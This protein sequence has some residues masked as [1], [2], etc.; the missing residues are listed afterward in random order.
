MNNNII[1]IWQIN[2]N[3]SPHAL[4]NALQH[5]SEING[6]FMC[7][8]EIPT[9]NGQIISWPRLNN[10]NWYH[11]APII[12]IP[13]TAVLI[14]SSHKASLLT[15]FSTNNMT[16]VLYGSII[17]VSG[18]FHA[19][20]DIRNDLQILESLQ[21]EFSSSPIIYCVDCNSHSPLWF[22]NHLDTRGKILENFFNYHNLYLLN[23]NT[24]PTWEIGQKCST[25]DL[26]IVNSLSLRHTN[27]W[28]ILD[29]QSYSDHK[30][31]SFEF[32]SN[33][34]FVKCPMDSRIVFKNTEWI[35]FDHFILSRNRQLTSLSTKITSKNCVDNFI[36]VFEKTILDAIEASSQRVVVSR[37]YHKYGSFSWWSPELTGLKKAVNRLRKNISKS[38]PDQV[39]TLKYNYNKLVKLYKDKIS[40]AKI[41]SWQTF[42]ESGN[43]DKWGKL[44][45]FI[46]K[47]KKS[48]SS[49]STIMKE[50][51][52][53]TLNDLETAEYLI[54]K[55]C[56]RN[57]P[58]NFMHAIIET[59]MIEWSPPNDPSFTLLEFRQALNNINF[60]S[61]PGPDSLKGIYL[62]KAFGLLE[63]PLLTVFNRCLRLGY[64]PNAWKKGKIII[65]PKNFNTRS[66]IS[67]KNYRPLTL[68]NISAKIFERMLYNRLYWLAE[69]KHWIDPNQFGFRAGR[70][71]TSSLIKIKNFIQDGFDC[72]EMAMLLSFD[73]ASAF[74]T[75]WHPVILNNLKRN[76]CPYNVFMLIQ[77]YLSDRVSFLKIG[78]H[79]VNR[80][81]EIGCP[82]GSILSP[83]LW[84][85]NFN[86]IFNIP[87]LGNFCRTAFADDLTIIFRSKCLDELTSHANGTINRIFKWGSNHKLSFNPQKLNCCIFSKRRYLNIENIWLHHNNIQIPVKREI[88]ILGVIFDTKLNF[89]S[90]V[91]NR[92]LKIKFI[93]TRM[94]S[95]I[96]TTFGSGSD[97]ISSCYRA[98]IRPII[99]YAA[100]VWMSVLKLK[101]IINKLNSLQRIWCIRICKAAPSIAAIDSFALCGFTHLHTY[102]YLQCKRYFLKE[103]PEVYNIDLPTNVL[104]KHYPPEITINCLPYPP[105]NPDFSIYTDGSKS[106][107]GVG[108][109][110]AVFHCKDP[111]YPIFT[112]FC[113]LDNKCSIFQAECL[114]LLEALKYVNCLPPSNIITFFTDSMSLANSVN[115]SD[116]SSLL[117]LQIYNLIK[118]LSANYKIYIQW[119]KSHINIYGNEMADS[120]AK[121]GSLS[122]TQKFCK[123]PLTHF[124]QLFQREGIEYFTAIYHLSSHRKRL[125]KFFPK[126]SILF[127]PKFISFES[128]IPSLILTA[129]GPVN[130]HL[131]RLGRS[132]SPN[133]RFCYSVE[134]SIDHLIF[135]CPAHAVYQHFLSSELAQISNDN[136]QLHA[137]YTKS[138]QAWKLLISF[139]RNLCL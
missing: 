51:G 48:Y 101:F 31:I 85:L 39:T 18:Y 34:Q 36:A 87:L 122:Q 88:K 11:R 79:T 66:P 16:T 64:F 59:S 109:G 111:I 121:T 100:P 134:E 118:S 80:T 105:E 22:N 43:N 46:S 4:T 83:L 73:I 126:L 74:D 70:S 23:I 89:R 63:T 125:L 30:I 120:L 25:I 114:A 81:L 1:K 131:F 52:S 15:Q 33:C 107:Q 65:I 57:P 115:N 133:C 40:K 138:P 103:S 29:E 137:S 49:P 8:Q 76:N 2:L 60:K 139:V 24:G 99:A 86:S 71:T 56:P 130:K 35:K 62:K 54:K 128:R 96:S 92:I 50:D 123:T 68:L 5:F 116:I 32:D 21:N 10:Y 98:L 45:S 119:V 90:H 14:K 84:L 17:I 27:N 129:H 124:Y 110:F 61:A 117:L 132:P 44:Y 41:A 104:E 42:C 13:N 53:F 20:E 106:P 127:K 78:D 136:P 113:S 58:N 72:G 3:R 55:F 47:G 12:G 91:H 77:S 93:T 6:D 112:D 75:A 19:E 82:Q 28:N 9:H 135:E 95:T 37:N 94:L 102:I 97:F 38:N 69:N 108:C 26:T 67:Y 7:I